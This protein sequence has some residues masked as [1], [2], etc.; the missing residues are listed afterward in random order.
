MT[1][2][3]NKYWKWEVDGQVFRV[4]RLHNNTFEAFKAGRWQ[5]S[6]MRERAAQDPEFIEIPQKEADVLIQYVG[7]RN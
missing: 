7:V 6:G 3:S 5:Q 4:Y 2:V 1:F